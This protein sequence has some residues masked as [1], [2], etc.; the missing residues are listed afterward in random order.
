MSYSVN[1]KLLLFRRRQ[2]GRMAGKDIIMVRQKELKRL[3]VIRK[4]LAGVITQAEASE[5]VSLSE[6]QIRRIVKRIREEGDGG[7]RHR[8]RGRQSNR[9]LP[10]KL[11]DRVI[12]LYR[13][14]YKGFGPTLA[15]EK[16]FE[17]DGIGISDETVRNWLMEAG[18]WKKG[19]KRKAYRQ[20]RPRKEHFGEMIQMDEVIMTGLS[21]TAD[22]LRRKGAGLCAC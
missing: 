9:R 5:T 17:M 6:R 21:A 20:W 19:H 11:K 2:D 1:A 12:E 16:L 10:G 7:I 18:E 4:V 13:Q 14:R 3:H 8:S 15:S 22:S